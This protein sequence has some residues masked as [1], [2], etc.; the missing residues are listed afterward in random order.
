MARERITPRAG[1]AV[2]DAAVAAAVSLAVVLAARRTL[3]PVNRITMGPGGWVS[4]RGAQSVRHFPRRGR[5]PQRRPWWAHALGARRLDGARYI[6]T[7][8][9]RHDR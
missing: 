6:I 1:A 7:P 8:R 2:F 4:I 3:A 9:G 5:E